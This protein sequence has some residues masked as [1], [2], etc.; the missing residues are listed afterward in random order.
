VATEKLAED[1][2]QIACPLGWLEII[3]GTFN[4][5][6]PAFEVRAGAHAPVMVTV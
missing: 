3:G 4:A 1:P 2:G 5:S 6:V